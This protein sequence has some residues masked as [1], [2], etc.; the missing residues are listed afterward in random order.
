MGIIQVGKYTKQKQKIFAII[1]TSFAD[2]IFRLAIKMF[3]QK[4][5][6]AGTAMKTK[7]QS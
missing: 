2:S 6:R 4:V 7:A 1:L 3:A 5:C